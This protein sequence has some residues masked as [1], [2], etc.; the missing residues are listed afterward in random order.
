MTEVPPAPG[1]REAPSWV[2]AVARFGRALDLVVAAVL[3]ALMTMTCIDVAGRELAATPLHGA[4]E[5][6]EWMLAAIVFCALPVATWRRE[7]IVVDL[8]DPMF[9]RRL[10]AVRDLLVNLVGAVA[11]AGVG[12]RVWGLAARSAEY[13]EL[14]HFLRLPVAP[15]VYLIAVFAGL[16]ALAM[17][18]NAL[19]C[20]AEARRGS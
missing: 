9:P 1:D 3:F 11:L 17:L 2:R 14:T 16:T 6:T 12:V 10:A 7:H 13:G 8:L 4:T 19:R 20:L 18:G 5:L 15:I